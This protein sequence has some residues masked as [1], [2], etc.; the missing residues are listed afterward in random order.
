M[1]SE[2]T[3]PCFQLFKQ[4]LDNTPATS[5]F[6]TDLI[7]HLKYRKIVLETERTYSL[8]K[9]RR[10]IGKRTEEQLKQFDVVLDN[11]SVFKGDKISIHTIVF[12][13][14]SYLFFTSEDTS[15]YFGYILVPN[16]YEVI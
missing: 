13:F 14:E 15:E 10:D 3:S 16:T 9:L 1:Y 4:L 5:P 2:V 11:L 6:F 12:R 8:Y 7:K